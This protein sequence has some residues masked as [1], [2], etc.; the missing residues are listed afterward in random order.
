MVTMIPQIPEPPT[1]QDPPAQFNQKAA[2]SWAGLYAAV[3]KMNQQAEEIAQIGAA[4]TAA[5]GQAAVDSDLALGYKNEAG[6]ARTAA[7]GAAATAGQ[8]AATAA[9]AGDDAAQAAVRA[10]EAAAAAGQR[11]PMTG[12]SGAAILP[13][14]PASDRP[15]PQLYQGQFLL[16]GNS[17]LGKLEW[18][19]WGALAWKPLGGGSSELFNYAW[20]NGPRSSIDV[21]RVPTDGQ[22]LL[23]LTH[24]D[25]CQAIWDGK[26]NAVDESVWQAD[27]TK[28]NCWS[29]GDGSTW[30]RVPDLNAAVAGTGKPFYLRGGSDSLNGTS[31]GDAIRNITAAYGGVVRATTTPTESGAGGTSSYAGVNAPTGSV[32]WSFTNLTFDASKVV[33]VADENRVKT[34]YGVMTVRVFTEVSNVGALDADQLA[35]QLGVVDAK[36]QALDAAT[37]FTIIYPNGGSAAS[38]ATVAINSRYVS[39][40]PFPGSYVMCVPQVL[41]NGIWGDPG[42]DGNTGS[43]GQAIGVRAGMANADVV[44]QTGI[45]ALLGASF[46]GG[47]MHGVPSGTIVSTP[48]PCRVLCWE[49]KG[50]M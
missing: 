6:A 31:V 42:W 30:V 24:P 23:L 14:G 3:P 44:V 18:Y 20:H 37:G 43:G 46:I 10:E 7:Q 29:R 26:Q 1:P 8:H 32:T 45:T 33:P 13:S 16:R 25:V 2:D 27:P 4:A 49:L 50:V 21:G 47:S 17:E 39:A 38:P 41:W 9:Q 11:V 12:M 40:N 22:Q 34:A 35:T 5:A 36:V 19:D 28:R 48:L 15:D